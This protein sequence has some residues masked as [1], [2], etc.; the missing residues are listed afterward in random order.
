MRESYSCL[1]FGLPLEA[2]IWMI[3]LLALAIHQPSHDAHVSLCVFSN[4][5]FKYCPGCGLGRSVSFLLHVQPVTS[6]QTHPFGIA[7]VA[8][9]LYRIFQLWIEYFKRLK[10]KFNQYGKRS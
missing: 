7:A 8:I 2:I 10:L 6:F 3:G 4:L 9:L 1:I 5:G